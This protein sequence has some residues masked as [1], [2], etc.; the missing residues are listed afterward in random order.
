MGTIVEGPGGIALT[1]HGMNAAGIDYERKRDPSPEPASPFLAINDPRL[2]DE[3]KFSKADSP[4]T[5][6]SRPAMLPKQERLGLE[7]AKDDPDRI[8][9][10]KDPKAG[11]GPPKGRPSPAGPGRSATAKQPADERNK[12]TSKTEGK[13]ASRQTSQAK[14]PAVSAPKQAP[15][16]K[17]PAAP[18]SKRAP[19]AKPPAASALKQAAL[20]KPPAPSTSKQPPPTKSSAGLPSKQTP[21]AK[22]PV[23][24]ASQQPPPAKG[25]APPP[26]KQAPPAKESAGASTKPR[27]QTPVGQNAPAKKSAVPAPVKAQQGPS[28][29]AKTATPT[30]SKPARKSRWGLINFFRTPGPGPG[31]ATLLDP[32]KLPGS[33]K[34]PDFRVPDFGGTDASGKDTEPPR[35]KAPGSSRAFASADSPSAGKSPALARSPSSARHPNRSSGSSPATLGS[36]HER[37]PS[38]SLDPNPQRAYRGD[39][40]AEPSPKSQP[41]HR[42]PSLEPQELARREKHRSPTPPPQDSA[43]DSIPAADSKYPPSMLLDVEIPNVSMDRYSVMFSSVLEP[44]HSSLMLRRRAQLEQLRVP[45]IPRASDLSNFHSTGLTFSSFQRSTRR[46]QSK[47]VYLSRPN[48]GRLYHLRMPPQAFLSSPQSQR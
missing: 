11:S 37:K 7:R 41:V 19:S 33:S 22:P 44:R 12:L 15:A 16:T 39:L 17:S 13:D 18:T 8:E 2:A 1:I 36:T 29:P 3:P 31:P 46:S 25:S 35:A 10:I 24:S 28:T 42:G 40:S 26:L 38:Q 45:E 48:A 9:P 47:R 5:T 23:T 4:E 30:S 27:T 6:A 43:S 20:A 14:L 34:A 21:L 32:S